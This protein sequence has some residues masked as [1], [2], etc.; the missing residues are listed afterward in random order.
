MHASHT[1]S[2]AP[3]PRKPRRQAPRW[4]RIQHRHGGQFLPAPARAR[5]A[6]PTNAHRDLA[7]QMKSELSPAWAGSSQRFTFLCSAPPQKAMTHCFLER[8]HRNASIPTRSGL[9][10]RHLGQTA[11]AQEVCRRAAPGVAVAVD[12]HT[13]IGGQQRIR[14]IIDLPK[15]VRASLCHTTPI[16]L[17]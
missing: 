17:N 11:T 15:C 4:R 3:R 2:R 8:L 14:G 13:L 5:L 16:G 10:S 7:G 12:V 6:V 1:S 9:S